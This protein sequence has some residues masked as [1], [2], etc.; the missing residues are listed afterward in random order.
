MG[1][2]IA[3]KVIIEDTCTNESGNI[4]NKYEFGQ[5]YPEFLERLYKKYISL[6]I[7]YPKVGPVFAFSQELLNDI[8]NFNDFVLSYS[9]FYFYLNLHQCYFFTAYLEAS[10][11]FNEKNDTFGINS[12]EK[13]ENCK[14][15]MIDIFEETYA[16]LLNSPNFLDNYSKMSDAN[17]SISKICQ[18]QF[19][20]FLKILNYPTKEDIDTILEEM[21][22]FRKEIFNIKQSMERRIGYDANKPD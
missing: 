5:D 9:K 6:V 21:T 11:K 8:S 12:N 7:K 13:Y 14:K 20:K 15:L 3:E 2:N 18:L 16:S 1:S 19:N 4:K 22:F 17:I 10:S